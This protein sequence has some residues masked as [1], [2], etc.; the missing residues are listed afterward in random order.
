MSKLIQQ[1]GCRPVQFTGT[2]EALYKR[3]LVFDNLM[4]VATIGVRERFEAIT[5]SVR[6]ILSQRWARKAVLNV[7]SSGKFSSDRTITE[8]AADIWHAKPCPVS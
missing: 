5:R 6:D 2:D 1:Y 7:A 8:Y 3:H 4:E